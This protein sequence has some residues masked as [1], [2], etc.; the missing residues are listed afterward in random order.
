MSGKMVNDH[1]SH[2]KTG[3]YGPVTDMFITQMCLGLG[4]AQFRINSKYLQLF[5]L[6][7]KIV[8]SLKHTMSK[9][10]NKSFI[11]YSSVVCFISNRRA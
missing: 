11:L 9:V 3:H 5:R 10:K 2:I 6:K 7:I 4:E 1:L 8:D